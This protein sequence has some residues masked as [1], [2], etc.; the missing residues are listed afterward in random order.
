MADVT[1][2]AGAGTSRSTSATI[3]P[4]ILRYLARVAQGRGVDLRPALEQV[5]LDE[6]V[7]RSADLRVS[8]RQGSAVIRRALELTGD[9]HLGMSVGAAQ[10]LTA[11]GLLGF[12]VM[13]SETLADA[14]EIGVRFQNLSGAMVVWSCGPEADTFVLRA[15]LPDPGLD[16][17]VGVFLLEE[18]LTSVVTVGRLAVGAL[19]LPRPVRRPGQPGGPRRA[20]GPPPDARARPRRPRLLVGAAGGADGV[21]P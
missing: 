5:G 3:Q 2:P 20:V 15:A 10:H 16:R 9:E 11:W 8:Y 19:R 7:M 17:A 21:S 13:A 6:E 4:N 14:I 12:A 18:A 1:V